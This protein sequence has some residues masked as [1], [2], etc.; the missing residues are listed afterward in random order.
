MAGQKKV[1][2]N[3]KPLI[4]SV[5]LE[6]K[7]LNGNWKEV[8]ST[9]AGPLNA[10]NFCRNISAIAVGDKGTIAVYQKDLIQDPIIVIDSPTK[11]DIQNYPNPF[12]PSTIISFALPEQ[13]DVELRIYDVLGKEVATLVNESKP[14]GSYEVEWNAS[15]LPS[16]V[17]I[18]QLRT[19]TSVQMKKMMLLK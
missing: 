16:G 5:I 9:V 3:G 11:V 17:Y 19:G 18:Y 6:S 8:F 15:D 13:T 14:A 10:V 7:D 12:N 4:F 2:L 1:Y